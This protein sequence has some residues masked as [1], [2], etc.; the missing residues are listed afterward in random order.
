VDDESSDIAS[1]SSSSDDSS[2]EC[3]ENATRVDIPGPVW[4]NRRSHVVHKCS[5]IEQQT[6]CGR[7]VVAANFEMMENGCST[8]NARC[9][10]CFK[11]EVITHVRGLVEA[12]DQ[13]KAKRQRDR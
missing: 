7:L 9:S 10:R 11:G 6:A 13:Q 3:V 5:E 4:R 12:L 8:L 1:S 2:S